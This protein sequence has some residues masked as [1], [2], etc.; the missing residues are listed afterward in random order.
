VSS[1]LSTLKWAFVR[2]P[3]SLQ[4]WS[5]DRNWNRVEALRHFKYGNYSEAERHLLIA[6]ED[7]GEQW[8]SA[9]K[10]VRLR[11]ELAD[12]QR[13]LALMGGGTARQATASAAK[14]A[15][16]EQTIRS[17]VFIAARASAGEAYAQ[18]LDALTE[19]FGAQRNYPAM[20]KAAEEAI[21]LGV[22]LPHPDQLRMARRV[23]WLG[24]ARYHNGR[25]A[26]AI[27]PLEKSLALHE[28][29][30]GADH[31]IT[32]EALSEVGRIYRAR[33][34]HEKAQE[35]LRRSLRIHAAEYG[36]D[37][38]Q[39]L[40]DL[41][42]LAG[43]YEDAGDLD[44]AAGEYERALLLKQRKLGVSNLEEV[45]EMQFS[46]ANIYLGWANFAR[47][48]EL[49]AECI[50]T[51]RRSGGPRLA[52][53]LET[54]AQLEER[55]GRFFDAVRDLEFAGTAWRKCE[56][57]VE[58]VRNLEYRADL[59]AQ[60]RKTREAKWLREQAAQLAEETRVRAEATT[61]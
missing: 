26:E 9:S 28:E 27:P 30:Y 54:Q 61:A 48:Q 10:R 19:V 11:L 3:R 41:A 5:L 56:H 17:A 45:A 4:G 2:A 60:L 18:C 24:I 6:V 36:P 20:E 50:G 37:S 53:A 25:L 44:A 22:S 33:G 47:A 12:V 34:D 43:S 42:A 8:L 16:A 35:C 59:L 15:E 29:N 39:A 14:L 49:L 13:R 58:L 1:L 31:L 51:F 46:L 40:D 23:H 57:Y 7:A 52:V 55:M 21:R 38:P 32:A